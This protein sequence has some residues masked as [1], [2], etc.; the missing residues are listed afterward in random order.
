MLFF[1]LVHFYPLQESKGQHCRGC[2]GKN[3]LR[4]KNPTLQ[5]ASY[6]KKI[7]GGKQNSL[8]GV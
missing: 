7:T 3:E 1:F 4:E 8:A 5:G 2:R 6:Q